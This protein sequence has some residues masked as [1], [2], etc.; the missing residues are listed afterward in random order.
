MARGRVRQG[1]V[2]RRTVSREACTRRRDHHPAGRSRTIPADPPQGLRPQDRRTHSWP[3]GPC[4]LAVGG[5]GLGA[6]RRGSRNAARR[7]LLRA[8]AGRRRGAA[9][10]SALA[11]RTAR[12][13]GSRMAHAAGQCA[14]PGD[15]VHHSGQDRGR[16]GAPPALGCPGCRGARLDVPVRR[17]RPGRHRCRGV[18]HGGP[19][20]GAS[21]DGTAA[22]GR[23][24]GR[25]PQGDRDAVDH[26]RHQ[27]A[28]LW[29]R[30]WTWATGAGRWGCN[31]TVETTCSGTDEM[32]TPR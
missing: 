8:G 4:S 17:G 12:R 31:T 9:V 20:G 15:G 2:R 21:R 30:G 23:P 19:I 13:H 29:S 1:R 3:E 16:S 28:V 7:E 22:G 11:Q 26:E 10:A 25:V 32:P 18:R 27:L 24:A 5:P 14:D 6:V